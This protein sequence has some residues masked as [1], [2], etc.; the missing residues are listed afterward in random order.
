MVTTFFVADHTHAMLPSPATNNLPH[1][2]AYREAPVAS[3]ENTREQ[4]DYFDEKRQVSITGF[5][6]G[7]QY[8]LNI[9]LE[10]NSWNHTLADFVALLCHCILVCKDGLRGR[11]GVPECVDS[12]HDRHEVLELVEV[13]AGQVHG[14]VQRVDERGIEG[15]KG[16]LV[17]D[18]GKVKR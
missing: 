12:R 1:P 8:R 4:V 15:P 3:N 10:E 7:E 6:D 5:F 18:V 11:M 17:D 16:E 14:A 2:I 9:V 13:T